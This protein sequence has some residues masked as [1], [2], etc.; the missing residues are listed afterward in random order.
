MK[1]KEVKDRDLKKLMK[2]IG[3][4]K[5]KKTSD[6]A[7]LIISYIHELESRVAVLEDQMCNLILNVPKQDSVVTDKIMFGDSPSEVYHS[8]KEVANG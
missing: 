4:I 7:Y 2:A 5:G 6:A 8:M 1:S 3:K